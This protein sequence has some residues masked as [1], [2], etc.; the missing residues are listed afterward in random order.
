M[1]LTRKRL[2]AITVFLLALALGIFVRR[3]RPSAVAATGRQAPQSA[4]D[5]GS[6]LPTAPPPNAQPA[7]QA[8]VSPSNPDATPE[9]THTLPVVAKRGDNVISLARHYLA[10]SVYLRESEFESAI[11]QANGLAGNAVKPGQQ[12][13]IP[14]IPATP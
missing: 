11:R 2:V 3:G 1:T 14:G 5:A 13:A 6:A 7:S 4:E 12:L 9:G 10:Q 8:S